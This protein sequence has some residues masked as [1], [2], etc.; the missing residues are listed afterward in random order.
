[1]SEFDFQSLNLSISPFIQNYSIEAQRDI[2]EYLSQL[3]DI[4]RKAYEIA[5]DHL[6]TSF[7]IARSNGFKEWKNK[8]SSK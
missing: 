4:H 7:N 1:M 5:Y 8:Q 3:D 6:G 2:Y